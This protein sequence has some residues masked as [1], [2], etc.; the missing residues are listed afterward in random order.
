ML[1]EIEGFVWFSACMP[2]VSKFMKMF[3]GRAV[4]HK[5]KDLIIYTL[6]EA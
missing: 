3:V 4:T 6:A 5:S 1:K 2:F